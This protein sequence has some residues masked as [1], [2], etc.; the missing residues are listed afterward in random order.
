M[1]KK[2]IKE[3]PEINESGSHTTWQAQ[4]R[5]EGGNEEVTLSDYTFLYRSDF[6]NLVNVSYVF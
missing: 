3:K 4:D 6:W 2:Q 5:R 1:Q